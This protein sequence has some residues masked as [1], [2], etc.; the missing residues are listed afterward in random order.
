MALSLPVLRGTSVVKAQQC[1]LSFQRCPNA[2]LQALCVARVGQRDPI[3]IFDTCVGKTTQVNKQT[4]I[5]YKH[6]TIN[7]SN[8]FASISTQQTRQVQA[9]IWTSAIIRLGVQAKGGN[10]L[11]ERQRRVPL[12][13]L[14]VH[15]ITLI[16]RRGTLYN[17]RQFRDRG[18][19]TSGYRLLGTTL[20][21]WLEQQVLIMRPH[22]TTG[23]HLRALITERVAALRDR[24]RGS[25]GN[26]KWSTQYE[27]QGCHHHART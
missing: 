5:Q 10:V 8:I 7:A 21:S 9:E 12:F 22:R 18:T 1:W 24:S 20:C 19:V 26:D 6:C 16:F 23:T 25:A 17:H 2:Q 14:L 11:Q 15:E 4:M 3:E 13:A 27:N